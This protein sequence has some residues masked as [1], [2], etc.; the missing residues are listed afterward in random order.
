MYN[1]YSMRKTL[2]SD[3]T[4]N[5]LNKIIQKYTYVSPLCLTSKAT[6]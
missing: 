6:G 2:P 1:N 5:E 3:F 4:A